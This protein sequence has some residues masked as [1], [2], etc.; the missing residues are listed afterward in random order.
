MAQQFG[1]SSQQLERDW[2]QTALSDTTDWKLCPECAEKTESLLQSAGWWRGTLYSIRNE[3]QSEIECFE[4][5]KDLPGGTKFWTYEV[6]GPEPYPLAPGALTDSAARAKEFR[7]KGFTFRNTTPLGGHVV[8]VSSDGRLSLPE[9][10][11]R[12]ASSGRTP[13]APVRTANGLLAKV[14][15][16]FRG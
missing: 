8:G 3:D 12:A 7:A 9:L 10:A 14:K 2:A 15:R 5:P 11:A 1:L 16:W 13:A 6:T 4:L